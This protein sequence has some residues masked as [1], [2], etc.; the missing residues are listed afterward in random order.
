MR[1]RF[2][3]QHELGIRA[4]E[5]IEIPTKSRD[6][7]PPVLMALQHIFVNTELSEQVFGIIEQRIVPQKM[8]KPGL[9]LWEIFV[10]GVVRLTLDVNY[11]RLEHISNYDS[12]VRELLGITKFG[13][14]KE[15]QYSLTSLKENIP[16]IDEELL[17]EINIVIVKAGHSLLKK[18]DVTE[19][20]KVRI[21]SYVLESNVHFPTDI[22]LLYDSIKSVIRTIEK[23]LGESQNQGWRKHHY[24]KKSSKNLSRN[25]SKVLRGGG[26]R[27]A[28]RVRK[29]ANA[30]LKAS[31]KISE[32][33]K[34]FKTQINQGGDLSA[35][36][37]ALIQDLN[38]YEM[39]LDKHIDLVERR[40]IKGEKIPHEE[41]I[42]SIYQPY[43]EWINKGKAGNR[44]ELGLKVAICTDEDGFILHHKIM[45]KEADVQI[46]VSIIEKIKENYQLMSASFDKGFWSKENFEKLTKEVPLLVLPK[47]GKRN[48][49]ENQREG[50]KKFKRLRNQHSAVES[51][52]NMLEHHGLNRC[53][54]K[55]IDHFKSYT[56]LGV[57]SYNLHRLGNLL[58][59]QKIVK[60]NIEKPNRVA[61]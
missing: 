33:I 2:E 34:A 15:K 22:T 58:K 10:L 39:M 56:A 11:D 28:Q 24:W 44:V 46:A 35:L 50:E 14:D 13:V 51:N 41:K 49:E 12:L 53:L 21:D 16:Y 4:I 48:R 37:I 19:G 55:G 36:K 47:K 43:T 6:E 38:Y 8:G 7:L 57:V 3:L 32:K 45:E 54:D 61:A 31:R 29:A 30:Y 27:K 26:K 17:A 42:F 9:S 20:K 5:D 25:L 60:E 1:K 23:L 40:L 18:K 52:I 59:K